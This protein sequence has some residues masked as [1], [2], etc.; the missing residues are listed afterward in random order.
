MPETLRRAAGWLAVAGAAILSAACIWRLAW[1]A[2]A[3]L[4]TQVADDTFYY[5]VLARNMAASGQLTFDGINTATGVHPAWLTAMTLLS[6]AGLDGMAFV[7]GA[8]AAGFLCHL[9]AG[10]LVIAIVREAGAPRRA[11]WVGALWLA[12]PVSLLLVIE[13]ME[14]PLF[15]AVLA[16][17]V[18]VV[19]RMFAAPEITA[20]SAIGASAALGLLCLVRTDGAMLAAMCGVVVAAVL[21]RRGQSWRRVAT[22][23]A[24]LGAGPVLAL[25]AFAA[26]LYAQTGF[27]TQSS[28]DLKMFWGSH[29]TASVKLA[30]AYHVFGR[31][32][33]GSF[34]SSM[35]G[36]PTKVSAIAGAIALAAV[37]ASAVRRWRAGETIA[38]AI[39][40]WLL[41]AATLATASYA[42][43]TYEYRTWYLGLPMLAM[44]LALV[45][46]AARRPPAVFVTICVLALAA[47]GFQDMR[48]AG[49][50]T[51]RYPYA[52]AIYLSV[53]L[54]DALTPPDEPIASFDAG[55]RGFFARHRVINLDGLVNDTI[56]RHWKAGTLD[57]YIK[58]EGIRFIADE[59]ASLAFARRFSR[60]PEARAIACVPA[61]GTPFADRCLWQ[62]VD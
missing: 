15:V 19:Q 9:A 2:D 18:L 44:F 1:L 47:M 40:I 34:G 23:V 46:E 26:F 48:L 42:L 30:Y 53:P 27:A 37:A 58:D 8:I 33:F 31:L 28:G 54:F 25:G 35:F 43:I 4:V 29:V 32:T 56:R 5:L 11:P 7:R 57:Q 21:R 22:M 36:L 38:P 60:F 20:R 24:L 14:A 45:L 17:T 50:R 51:G 52:R 12:N 10:A 13:G 6:A 41:L 16:G 55:V 61:T 39:A 59:P 62:I 3:D 49:T